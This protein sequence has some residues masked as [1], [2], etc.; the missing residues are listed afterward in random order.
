MDG[1]KISRL[2][3][4]GKL[5]RIIYGICDYYRIKDFYE[6]PR[7]DFMESATSLHQ[8]ALYISNV[9]SSKSIRTKFG[10]MQK[11]LLWW[12]SSSFGSVPRKETMR[13]L[14][15]IPVFLQKNSL[16]LISRFERNSL[17]PGRNISDDCCINRFFDF[18]SRDCASSRRNI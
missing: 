10:T 17:G 7:Y 11:C 6:V 16:K 5:S 18:R 13:Y 1:L 8:S 3:Q 12:C 14:S 15:Q 9:F 4:T 2:N